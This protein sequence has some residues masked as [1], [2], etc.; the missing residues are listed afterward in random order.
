MGED[1][2]SKYRGLA[3]R[4]NYL[5]LDRAD[6]QHAAKECCRSMSRPIWEIGENSN[7]LAGIFVVD[8]DRFKSSSLRRR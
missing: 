4:L 1:S 3:A 5:A 8:R 7:E 2:A 6:V